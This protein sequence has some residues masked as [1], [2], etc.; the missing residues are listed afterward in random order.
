MYK[1]VPKAVEASGGGRVTILRGTGD[2]AFEP[3]QTSM[4]SR[5]CEQELLQRLHTA[6]S[7]RRR[8]GRSSPFGTLSSHAFTGRA[9]AAAS[10]SP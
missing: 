2:A 7:R 1:D 10:I 4:S 6:T 3:G 9:S 5:S 8:R